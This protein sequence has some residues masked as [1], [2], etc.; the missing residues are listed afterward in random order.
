MGLCAAK[1]S[2]PPSVDN[3]PT[4]IHPA[5]RPGPSDGRSGGPGVRQKDDDQESGTFSPP[6]QPKGG[7]RL[8]RRKHPRGFEELKPASRLVERYAI[9]ELVSFL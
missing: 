1:P 4:D 7:S 9:G 3:D 8:H 2:P 5:E 6:P